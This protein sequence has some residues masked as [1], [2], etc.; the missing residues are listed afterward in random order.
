MYILIKNKNLC[1]SNN[2]SFELPGTSNI[3]IFFIKSI[4]M[5]GSR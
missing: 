4:T 5:P 2:P 1:F 3:S